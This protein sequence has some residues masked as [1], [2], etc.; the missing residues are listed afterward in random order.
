MEEG[1]HLPYTPWDQLREHSSCETGTRTTTERHW[2]SPELPQ[3]VTSEPA[4]AAYA[5]SHEARHCV[6]ELPSL[7]PGLWTVGADPLPVVLRFG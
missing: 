6:V 3:R 1:P 2:Q 7:R 4:A 5:T